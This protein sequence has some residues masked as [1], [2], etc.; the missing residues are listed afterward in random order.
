MFEDKLY[1]IS[2]IAKLT[3][4]TD[5]T[6]RNYLANGT[7]KGRKVGGQWRFTKDDIRCLFS[8]NEFADDMLAK[9]EK[10]ISKYVKSDFTFKSVNNGCFIINFVVEDKD[11]RI[12]L[13]KRINELPTDEDKKEKVS[14]IET[15]G[16]IKMVIIASLDYLFKIFRLIEDVIV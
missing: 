15:N 16:K 1:S 7:L 9:S 13:F 10:N 6:I 8:Q 4:L 3:K 5:R 11:K 12:N 2:D 14:F